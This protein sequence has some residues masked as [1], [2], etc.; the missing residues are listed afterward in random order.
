MS[1]RTI[2]NNLGK[3]VVVISLLMLIPM[4]ISLGYGEKD[5]A[6]RF[7]TVLVPAFVVGFLCSRV[8][9]STLHP[10][11][12]YVMKKLMSVL[13]GIVSIVVVFYMLVLITAWL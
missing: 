9:C 5:D 10:R 1:K 4:F 13:F 8:K 7:L 6:L 11:D 3:I 2:I 12:G